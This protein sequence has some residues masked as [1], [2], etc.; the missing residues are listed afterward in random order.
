ME[1]GSV[2]VPQKQT[3][4]QQ[5][6]FDWMERGIREPADASALPWPSQTSQSACNRW[7]NSRWYTRAR[8]ER[9]CTPMFF[10]IIITITTII[11]ICL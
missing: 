2:T 3:L 11:M 4:W 10:T 8:R 1:R 9:T 7:K 5:M 6:G